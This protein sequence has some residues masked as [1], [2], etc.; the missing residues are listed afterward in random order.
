MAGGTEVPRGADRVFGQMTNVMRLG[1]NWRGPG[2]AAAARHITRDHPM[3]LL[4]LLPAAALALASFLNTTDVNAE[5][6]GVVNGS[7]VTLNGTVAGLRFKHDRTNWD[8]AITPAGQT[9]GPGFVTANISNNASVLN[10]EY[11]FTAAYTVGDGITW[12]I[13]TSEL[14]FGTTASFNAI[15]LLARANEQ[16]SNQVSY[17][18]SIDVTDLSFSGA[19]LSGPGP[20]AD[21]SLTNGQDTLWLVSSGDLSLFDWMLTGTVQ[22]TAVGG[23]NPNEN[24]KLDIGLNSVN[25]IPLPASLW[26]LLGGLGSL[27]LLRRRRARA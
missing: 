26:L 1:G 19:G 21:I 20:L 15:S 13:G 3:K 12:T 17:S 22:F 4:N 10:Q 5:T 6:V 18:R 23:P 8:Q 25:V 24:T 27:A 11:D 7:L 16:V 9:S 14:S 2:L